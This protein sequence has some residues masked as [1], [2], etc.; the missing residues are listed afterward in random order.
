M[1]NT[2]W[3][4]W[5]LNTETGCLEITIPNTALTYQVR[6]EECETSAQQLDWIFQL[7]E[8]TWITSTDIGDLVKALRDTFGRGVASMGKDHPID[9]REIINRRYSKSDGSPVFQ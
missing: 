4:K 5:T 1:A 8:K 2:T 9:A 3:G 7:A 6:L